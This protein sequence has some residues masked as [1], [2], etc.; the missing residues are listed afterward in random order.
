MLRLNNLKTGVKLTGGFGVVALLLALVAIEGVMSLRG[1]AGNQTSMFEDRVLPIDQLAKVSAALMQLRGD[2]YKLIELPGE[3]AKTE[4]GVLKAF[5]TIDRN[6]GLYRAT[7]L[8]TEEKEGLKRFDEAWRAYHDGVVQ[9]LDETKAGSFK[10]A[11]EQLSDTGS[12][13]L[14]RRAVGAA[15]DSGLIR[16]QCQG[17]RDLRKDSDAQVR[18]A[19]RLMGLYGA[20]GFLAALG[21]GFLLTRSLTRPLARA[22]H[23]MQGL[24]KGHLGLR[25]ALGRADESAR[26]R[27]RWTRSPTTSSGASSGRCSKSRR[28][29]WAPT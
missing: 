22:V 14:A 13:A 15:T 10:S 6:I 27:A 7:Y 8:V 1:V 29:T 23:M 5:D 16:G 20:A 3:R 9:V 17:G 26:W 19:E 2:T 21:L 18:G 4:A 24:S 11:L 12:V 25:L 28:A